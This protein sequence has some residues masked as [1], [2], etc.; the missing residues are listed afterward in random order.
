MAF[1]TLIAGLWLI[2]FSSYSIFL[3]VVFRTTSLDLGMHSQLLWNLAHGRFMET[4][5]LTYSFA[6]NHFWPFLYIFVP[7]YGLF[8]ACGLLVL[9]C[10]V[11][12]LG[13]FPVYS[14]THDIT[15]NKSW[16]RIL[17]LAYLALPTISMGVLFDF[18][19]ELLS[20]PLALQATLLLRRGRKS[21]WF[22]AIA[23][24]LF[25]EVN[26]ITFLLFGI[27]LLFRKGRR[28]TGSALAGISA[29][30]LIIVFF[31]IMP[32]FRGE[33]VLPH[34]ERYSHLGSTPAKASVQLF[35]NPI[36]SIQDSIS[37]RDIRQVFFLLASVSLLP[38]LSLKYMIP[39]M[40]VLLSLIFSN[41]EVQM[42]VRYAYYAP[43]VPCLMLSAAHGARFINELKWRKLAWFQRLA[44]VLS[45]AEMSFAFLFFQ[46]H[47]P[48]RQNP[49]VIRANL[50]ELREAIALIPP[51]ASVSADNHLGPRLANREVLL[52]TPIIEYK[53]ESVEYI[54]IDMLE[55]EF[56][57]RHWRKE[58]KKI[59][60]GTEYGTIY[61]SK[62]VIVLKRVEDVNELQ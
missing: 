46:I 24:M 20:I 39:A 14:L 41:W 12:A 32:A 1:L 25:Y 9:Q 62:G 56:K 38:L 58:M 48:M 3:H 15:G 53:D 7:F 61:S 44:P 17:S 13:V 18:H 60:K 40:P 21:F 42:D 57:G 55:E 49:F 45:L 33:V 54:F 4:S 43:V 6:G 52:L 31:L 51:R 50:K 47:S 59:L 23:A 11:A 10:V 30:Y 28:I 19:I 26:A 36:E 27:G 5:F 34:W 2:I 22:W 16:A 37:A 29:F 8:G 35:T